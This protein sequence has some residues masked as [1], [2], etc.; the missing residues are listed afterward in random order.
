MSALFEI[1]SAWTVY[2]TVEQRFVIFLSDDKHEV[3]ARRNYV[4]DFKRVNRFLYMKFC[5]RNQFEKAL[6]GGM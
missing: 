3:E 5:F 2:L 1:V 4:K 6:L